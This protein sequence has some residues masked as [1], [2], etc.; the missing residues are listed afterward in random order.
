MLPH[1]PLQLLLHY[2]LQKLKHFSLAILTLLTLSLLP[3]TSQAVIPSICEGRIF[4]PITDTDWNNIFPITVMGMRYTANGNSNSPLMD[5]MP[6]VCVCPTYL[7]GMPF[8][9][10]GVTYWEPSYISEI[11]RRPGCLSSLGGIPILPQF[12]M[13]ASEN[14]QTSPNGAKTTSRMQVHWY[15]YPIMALID[16]FADLVCR[17]PSGVALAYVTEIDPYWQSDVLA[18]IAS[19][20]DVLFTN[21]VAQ[22]ACSID[23]VSSSFGYPLDPLFWCAGSWGSV[24]PM[25]GNSS[26]AGDP[27]TT[28]N[29]LQAKFIARNHRVG[30][31]FQTIGPTAICFSHINPIWVKSQYRYNQV[32][33]LPRYGRAVTTGDIGRTLTFPPITNLPTQEHTTNLIWQ[34]QQCCVRF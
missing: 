21:P 30:V 20:E 25:S 17:T 10:I 24:Y 6:P 3:L 15:E 19:P 13:L 34:G 11:E 29:Q 31:M 8:F 23:A 33:P 22:F 16:Y 9:G 27:F 14:A 2:T 12:G 28:N 26:I 7:M 18:S 4:S 1:N 5:M 32:A